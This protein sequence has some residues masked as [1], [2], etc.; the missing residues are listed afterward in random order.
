MP[1]FV[2]LEAAV[3]ADGSRFSVWAGR[4]LSARGGGRLGT[5]LKLCPYEV[6]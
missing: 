6:L 2:H 4:N 3:V 5:E 1:M